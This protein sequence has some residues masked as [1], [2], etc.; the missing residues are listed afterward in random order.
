[1]DPSITTTPLIIKDVQKNVPTTSTSATTTT[2]MIT[3]MDTK[4]VHEAVEKALKGAPNHSMT[5][6]SSLSIEN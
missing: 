3:T 6:Q 4:K 2:H 1:M 5:L